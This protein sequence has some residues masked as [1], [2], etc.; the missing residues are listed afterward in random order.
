M[1]LY[2]YQAQSAEELSVQEDQTLAVCF[3]QN[4]EWWLCFD[5]GTR[6]FG[7]VPAS[8]LMKPSVADSGKPVSGWALLK[9]F[10]MLN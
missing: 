1:A 8:Y 6:K 7:L 4:E 9:W 5:A 2:S 3:D 10:F